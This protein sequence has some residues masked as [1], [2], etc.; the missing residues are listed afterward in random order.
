MSNRLSFTVPVSAQSLYEV[1]SDLDLL[2][3]LNIQWHLKNH[4]FSKPINKESSYFAQVHYDR[5]DKEVQYTV[6]V[7]ELIQDSLM[8][9]DLE[10]QKQRRIVFRIQRVSDKHSIFTLEEE[11]QEAL[12]K[13][14]IMELNLWA[15]SIINYAMISES[16]RITSRIWKFILD[17]IWLKLSP[18]GR[19]VVFFIIISEIF[20]LLF[21]I[22]LVIYFLFF[23]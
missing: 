14:E 1:I 21:F 16:K 18:T 19:R 6:K 23:D 7:L 20:G 3:R 8:I 11:A 13:A 12:N 22:I 4:N 5:E 9:I 2:F 15:K 17:K 10:G